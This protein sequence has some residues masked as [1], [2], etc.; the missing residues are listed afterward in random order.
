[1]NLLHQ[2]EVR[3]DPNRWRHQYWRDALHFAG[4]EYQ[5]T[6]DGTACRYPPT[7]YFLPAMVART[8]A[9]IHGELR[10]GSMLRAGYAARLTNWILT[11]LAVLLMCWRLP[12]LRNFTL[13]FYSIP[14]AIQQSMAVNT[15]SFLFVTT[16]ALLLLT[17]SR[18]RA[19][20]LPAIGLVVALMAMIKPVY[21][22]LAALGL[23]M[24]ERLLAQHRWRWRD[25]AA[26]L[27]CV[28]VVWLAQSLWTH[29][30]VHA[31]V[32]PGAASM[33]PILLWAAMLIWAVRRRTPLG[34][35]LRPLPNLLATVALFLCVLANVEAIHAVLL[36]FNGA[37]LE[38]PIAAPKHY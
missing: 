3:E 31:V 27:S 18:P 37:Y 22:P 19:W 24:W 34:P 38:R 28:A 36:R 21:A 16:V 15:D 26:G 14:E 30:L 32:A 8:V 12:W 4:G 29:W 6:T 1:L 23:I 5:V 25:L 9:F 17:F 11:S 35:R 13:F 33:D 7:P 2:K 20:A 10:P